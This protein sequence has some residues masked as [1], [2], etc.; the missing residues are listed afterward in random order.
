MLIT[1]AEPAGGTPGFTLCGHHCPMVPS[2]L[3]RVKQ[4][5]FYVLLLLFTPKTVY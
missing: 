3:W 1:V 2:E 5:Q 4:Q